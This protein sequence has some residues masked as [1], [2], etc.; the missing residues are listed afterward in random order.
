[1]DFPNLKSMRCVVAMLAAL[2]INANADA[3]CATPLGD[4][5]DT[6][7]CD[8]LASETL[9]SETPASEALGCDAGPTGCDAMCDC[10]PESSCSLCRG[11]ARMMGQ[12]ADNGITLQSN[13]TQFYFGNTTGGIEREFR[14]GGHG[15][16]LFNADLG[17]LGIQEGLFLKIRAEH[18]FGETI[19]GTTGSLFPPTLAAD[20]PVPDQ[21]DLYIT[22][23]LLT[24]ALSESFVVFAGKT[25]TLDG[26]YNAFAHG[27]GVRQFSNSAFVANPI[28]LRSVPYSTLGLGFAYLLDGKPLLSCSLLNAVDTTRTIGISDLFEEGVVMTAELIL[29]TNFLDKPGQQLFAATYNTRTFVSLDQDPRIILPNVPVERTDGSW[30]LYWNMHQYLVSDRSN[31]AIGWGVFAR[32]GIADEDTN[33]IRSFLSAGLGGNSPLRGRSQ[34]SFGIGYYFAE[35][36]D[37]IGPILTTVLGPI[38]DGH[39]VETFY[40]VAVTEHVTITP[41]V[42][43]IVPARENIDTALVAGVRM[44]I[45]F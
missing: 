20:L 39:G 45:A 31:P 22:N 37:E 11:Y 30:S 42:Q 38:N 3:D 9:A 6:V 1:M 21:E 41:D 10:P 15:D 29:P 26:D 32:A 16:Y 27:R 2:T 7:C 35:S 8:A 44:N 25:D 19:S 34:D 18:R 33:P 40:N 4:C 24:Q 17:K 28:A 5:F 14:Y 12:L 36:S 23:F 13:I 43:V